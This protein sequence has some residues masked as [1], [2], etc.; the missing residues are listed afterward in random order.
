MAKWMRKSERINTLAEDCLQRLEGLLEQQAK[1][2]V[3][4]GKQLHQIK[5]RRWFVVWGY[6]TFSEW[7]IGNKAIL[8]FSPARA[9]Q[10]VRMADLLR[11]NGVTQ[12][13]LEA[14]PETIVC[15]IARFSPDREAAKIL[16]SVNK[17]PVRNQQ[18]GK[19][20]LKALAAD[21]GKSIRITYG[22]FKFSDPAKNIVIQ[23]AFVKARQNRGISES[24][25]FYE[26][27][28]AY[29]QFCGGQK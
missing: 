1:T 21:T 4:I 10:L 20:F 29:L 25:A 13:K 6:D 24:E 18:R 2:K 27:C 3:E 11:V 22:T 5:N 26:I 17:A 12:E 23:Q 19:N 9:A 8:N 14:I 28:E 7:V 16:E 15:E